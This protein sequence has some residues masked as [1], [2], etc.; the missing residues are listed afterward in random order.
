[1]STTGARQAEN[2]TSE[3]WIQRLQD[4]LDAADFDGAVAYLDK[5]S[6]D[7]LQRKMTSLKQG[8]ITDLRARCL[9][10]EVYDYAG[11]NANADKVIRP[12]G[13][14]AQRD[15]KSASNDMSV[16]AM[17]GDHHQRFLAQQ[18]WACLHL[19]MV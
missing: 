1:M 18:C 2:P 5:I 6:A 14:K 16:P 7:D 11:L 17:L 13:L 4:M 10:S 3:P 8:S 12:V 19:G 15:I 9:L